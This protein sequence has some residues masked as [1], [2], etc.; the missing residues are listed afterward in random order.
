[1]KRILSPFCVNDWGI[2]DA[3]TAILCL[4]FALWGVIGL[5]ALGLH[6]PIIR[7]LIASA[8][9]LYVPGILVL[10]I[11]NVHKLGQI[12]SLL[13]SIGGSIVL[14]LL[15]GLSL[16]SASQAF[17][18]SR[19]LST[20]PLLTLISATV[21]ALCIL[22][23]L[24]DKGF[25]DPRFIDISSLRAPSALCLFSLPFLS[26]FSTYAFNFYNTNSLQI[27][28]LLIIGLIVILIGFGRLIPARLYPLAIFFIS[29]ALVFH[30]SLISPYVWGYDIQ[31]ESYLANSVIGNGFWDASTPILYNSVASIVIFPPSFSVISGM[32]IDWVFK[33]VFPLLF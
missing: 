21:L 9:L 32:D 10:R 25:C 18:I 11:L 19:P 3:L 13:Y 24:R 14:T 7:E 23:Y 17:G 20:V 15:C 26:I 4:Q 27:V 33:V 5:D 28:L 29:V 8:L 31:V 30:T 22:A 6:I 1:M 16:N 2:R 12:E